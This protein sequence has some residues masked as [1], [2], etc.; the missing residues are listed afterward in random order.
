MAR[1]VQRKNETDCVSWLLVVGSR[2]GALEVSKGH[3][4]VRERGQ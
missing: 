3:L 1:G 2:G 4:R